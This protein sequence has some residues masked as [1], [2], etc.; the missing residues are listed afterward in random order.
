MMM[1][2]IENIQRYIINNVMNYEDEK[3]GRV[4]PYERMLRSLEAPYERMPDHDRVLGLLRQKFTEGDIAVWFSFPDFSYRIQ[5]LTVEEAAQKAEPGVSA[6]MESAK[7]LI[8]EGFLVQLPR[9][10]GGLGYVRTYMLYLA[11]GSVLKNDHDPLTDA[12][13]DWWLHILRDASRLRTISPEHRVLPHEESLPKTGKV[14]MGLQIPDTR[15]VLP[16]DLSETVLRGVDRIAVIDCVCRAATE[17]RGMREC[18]YPIEGVC[19]LFNEAAEEAIK[20]GYGRE[21]SHEE[22]I[23]L[24]HRLRDMGLVQVISNSVRPL[25]MCNCCSCCCICLNSIMRNERTMAV[26]SRFTA[27]V[28][29]ADRCIGCGQCASFCQASAISFTDSGVTISEAACFGCGQCAAR[30]PAEVIGMKLKA[31]APEGPARQSQD[32]IYL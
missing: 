19:F 21:L 28:I 26:P 9:Q 10:D 8:D 30:C 6:V 15:Q 24:L 20:V 1:D 17:A 18:D 27:Q 2:N 22:G 31:G 29:Q 12:F 13:I 16:T 11:F 3:A 25:S 23:D 7:K 14:Q 4:D 32:R 5:P